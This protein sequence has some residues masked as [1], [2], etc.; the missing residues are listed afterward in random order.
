MELQK[1]SL[2]KKSKILLE[3]EWKLTQT[4]VKFTTLRKSLLHFE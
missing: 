3:M 2:C 4:G 1:G